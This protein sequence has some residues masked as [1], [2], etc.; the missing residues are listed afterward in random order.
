MKKYIFIAV[1]LLTVAVQAAI[2]NEYPAVNVSKEARRTFE[3]EYPGAFYPSWHQLPDA[4]V[5]IVRFGY[6]GQSL[7][8]Y[9]DEAGELLATVRNVQVNNLPFSVSERLNTT[10]GNFQPKLIEELTMEGEASYLLLMEN[11]KARITVRIYQSGDFYEM[12]KVRKKK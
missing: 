11:E 9:I 6:N 10:Y 3:R 5:Y 1:L 4:S 2:A 7:L 8:S 12:K